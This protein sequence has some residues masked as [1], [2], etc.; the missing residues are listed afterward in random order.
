MRY[1]EYKK[2]A[3]LI[4]KYL[5]EK[6]GVMALIDYFAIYYLLLWEKHTVVTSSELRI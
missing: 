2:F 1:T 3:N 5:W 4:Q 6:D